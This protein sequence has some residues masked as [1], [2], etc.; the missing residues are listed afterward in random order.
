M[1]QDERDYMIERSKRRYLSWLYDGKPPREA[2]AAKR[3]ELPDLPPIELPALVS[4]F[5]ALGAV[6]V[7]ALVIRLLR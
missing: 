3:E 6:L 5:L 4:V 1:A 7:V 2:G